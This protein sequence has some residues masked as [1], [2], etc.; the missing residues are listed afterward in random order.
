[1]QDNRDLDEFVTFFLRNRSATD[2][3][4][5]G[6]WLHLIYG[7]S[8]D[9]DL[10]SAHDA[11]I[12]GEPRTEAGPLHGQHAVAVQLTGVV[13]ARSARIVGFHVRRSDTA[14][15]A[16]DD[17]SILS[18]PIRFL[19]ISE[20]PL[21]RISWYVVV[22]VPWDGVGTRLDA[23]GTC[24]SRT[25]EWE[26]AHKESAMGHVRVRARRD[27]VPGELRDYDE[28]IAQMHLAIGRHSAGTW[29]HT[30]AE[31]LIHRARKRHD[32]TLRCAD[33][34]RL[35][36]PPV[37]A[38]DLE[39]INCGT[40]RELR[41]WV[42]Q[43]TLSRPFVC[44]A[45]RV[46]RGNESTSELRDRLYM[47]VCERHRTA[48]VTS[49]IP[50]RFADCLHDLVR[51]V[52]ERRELGPSLWGTAPREGILHDKLE[53]FLRASHGEVGREVRKANGRIDL[54][55][56]GTPIELKATP[57]GPQPIKVALR[58]AQ[59]AA[60]Y[61]AQ[62]HSG[63]AVLM[64]LNTTKCQDDGLHKAHLQGNT[65]VHVVESSPSL[66][67]PTA[68]V[69]VILVLNAFPPEPSSLAAGKA[70]SRGRGSR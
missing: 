49:P 19:S 66:R 57:L 47:E 24:T 36:L 53:E 9:V 7:E 14:W 17:I 55:M 56:A 46:P 8:P 12:G 50:G 23:E 18:D 38:G 25:A 35:P 60:D 3:D 30:D 6:K 40:Q 70:R 33:A 59:Q 69:V 28:L 15:M 54:L 61:G 48:A 34:G 21:G 65:K 63:V 4:V 43:L 22:T 1:M 13:E 58:F 42:R 67:G 45:I 52:N 10:R 11:F 2:V 37:D 31:T 64:V 62:C 16:A 51:F 20:W 27:Y 39:G 32:A 29:S 68:T 44:N 26:F 41:R 5:N